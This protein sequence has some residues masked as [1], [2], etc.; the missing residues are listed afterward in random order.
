MITTFININDII[1]KS[2]INEPLAKRHQQINA[3]NKMLQQH[4][5]RTAI[6]APMQG[7]SAD[8]IKKAMLDVDAWIGRN[9]PDIKMI[10]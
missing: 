5:L 2:H 10:V 6:N 7:S 1:A 9:N 8:I 4:A 3:K